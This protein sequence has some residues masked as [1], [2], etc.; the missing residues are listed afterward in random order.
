MVQKKKLQAPTKAAV[1]RK[2]TL[3]RLQAG[4][5]GLRED[6]VDD[7]S[8]QQQNDGN[9]YRYAAIGDRFPRNVDVRIAVARHELAKAYES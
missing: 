4:V 7:C 5:S 9:T 3:V 6:E 8:R 1:G 2:G